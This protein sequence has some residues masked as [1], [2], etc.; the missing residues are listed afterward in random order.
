MMA[1]PDERAEFAAL[2]DDEKTPTNWEE[3]AQKVEAIKRTTRT[4]LQDFKK[5]SA[6]RYE[7]LTS[8]IDSLNATVMR[9]IGDLRSLIEPMAIRVGRLTNES[10]TVMAEIRDTRRWRLSQSNMRAP[11]SEDYDTMSNTAKHRALDQKD[12]DL[13]FARD[14]ILTLEK[15]TADL[16]AQDAKDAER[17]EESRRFWR[18][19]IIGAIVGLA[20]II[21]GG[22]AVYRMTA[23]NTSVTIEQ[24]QAPK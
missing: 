7:K 23:A 22:I 13:A 11:D 4:E 1:N 19:T 24:K 2:G 20:T 6:T 12:V 18:N 9:E 17:L 14:K 10:D 8:E 15:Q 16:Q 21:F 3:L 5:V